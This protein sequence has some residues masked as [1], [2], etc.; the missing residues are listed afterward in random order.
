MASLQA[1]NSSIRLLGAFFYPHR[2]LIPRD[3]EVSPTCQPLTMQRNTLIPLLYFLYS[4]KCPITL[5]HLSHKLGTV[6]P[7]LWDI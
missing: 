4:H 3:K 6:V 2:E 1:P 5:G 7:A